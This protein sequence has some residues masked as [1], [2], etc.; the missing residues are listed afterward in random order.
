[1]RMKF[2]S[3]ARS[4]VDINLTPLIDVVFL[5]LIFFMVS[6]TFKKNTQLNIQLPHASNQVS[7]TESSVIRILIDSKGQYE[8]DGTLY[9]RATLKM[10]SE[11][12]LK[13]Y[14]QESPLFIMGDK[15]APHQSLV[16]LLELAADLNISKVRILAQFED[17]ED[18]AYKS[19]EKQTH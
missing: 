15:E 13:K 14:S 3:K 8:L 10:L 4:E 2:R 9:N 11:Q 19:Y 1:M 18:N 16:S 7:T 17:K 6:T 12:L 5:L